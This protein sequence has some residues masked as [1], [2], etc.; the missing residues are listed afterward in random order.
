MVS[1]LK[2]IKNKVKTITVSGTDLTN[3]L[4]V[5]VIV[6][7]GFTGNIALKSIEGLAELIKANLLKESQSSL[8]SKIGLFLLK[9]SIKFCRWVLY[10][11]SLQVKTTIITPIRRLKKLEI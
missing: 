6:T 10:L 9:P 1:F 11:I 5:D 2:K 3:D 4:D 7:D 8:I